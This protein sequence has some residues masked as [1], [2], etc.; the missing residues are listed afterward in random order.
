MWYSERRKDPLAE[1]QRI[2]ET[3][4]AIIREDI[5]SRAYNNE[6]YFSNSQV[7]TGS[8]ELVPETLQT[9]IEGI[10]MTN[11]KS[12]YQKKCLIIAH[13]IISAARHR[14]F[15]S[16]ILTALTV[17]L[18]RYYGSRELIDILS[19]V[20]VC[21][22]YTE[23]QRYESS[24]LQSSPPTIHP[25]AFIQFVFDNADFNVKTLDGFGTFH[26]FFY[27]RNNIV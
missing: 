6:T 1:R 11:K 17:H 5:T 24:S 22:T 3:A 26:S 16:P 27:G 19:Q 2:V 14:S 10:V 12:D 7:Q 15:L 4:V 13:A 21:G 23:A 8:R 25:D 18:H 20:G 9:L